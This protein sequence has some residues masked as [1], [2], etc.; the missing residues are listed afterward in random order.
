LTNLDWSENSAENF[1]KTPLLDRR[2]GFRERSETED[3][4]VEYNIQNVIF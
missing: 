2:G 1:P 4:V 3:G